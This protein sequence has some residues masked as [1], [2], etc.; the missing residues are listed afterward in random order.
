[1]VTDARAEQG[2][3]GSD[4]DPGLDAPRDLVL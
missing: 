3:S 4:R 1:L 2:R